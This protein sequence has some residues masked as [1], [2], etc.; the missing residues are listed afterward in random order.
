V[1]DETTVR[2]VSAAVVREDGGVRRLLLGQ[3]R[4]G[5]SYPLRWC[6]LGGKVEEGETWLDALCRELAE[7]AGVYEYKSQ[8][9]SWRELFA[10]SGVRQTDGAPFALTCFAAVLDEPDRSCADLT[11]RDGVVGVGWFTAEEVAHLALAAADE[12]H[13]DELVALLRGGAS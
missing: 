11:P 7:E 5:G 10:H 8:Y 4:A 6:T 13:R 2:V 1:I 9:W 12:A 3:R